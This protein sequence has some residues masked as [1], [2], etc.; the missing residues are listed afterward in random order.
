MRI[1]SD[2]GGVQSL[3]SMILQARGEI[4][5]FDYFVFANTGDDSENPATLEYRRKY[6]RVY[7]AAFSIKLVTVQKTFKGNPD[8]LYQLMYRTKRSVPLPMY[9][10]KGSPGI[11]S[12]SVEFKIKQ[13]NRWVKSQGVEACEVGL[14]ISTDEFTRM[15]SEQWRSTDYGVELGFKKKLFHPL[16]HNRISRNDCHAIIFAAGL[17]QPPKSAC[18]FC[19]MAKP[20]EWL[21]MKQNSPHLFD[22]AV[23]LEKRLNNK[24]GVDWPS[25]DYVFLHRYLSPL[26]LA[27]ADQQTLPG[28]ND[29]DYS[30]G[31]SCDT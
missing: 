29:S 13:V 10:S 23:E 17:P 15:K 20:P 19:P 4:E 31:S 14:G 7:A 28:F 22:R 12:C 26:D 5:P 11:H 25:S 24:R 3:A 8:T 2:G 1:Y 21:R 9:R 30:C 16:I 6:T 27:V 18:W